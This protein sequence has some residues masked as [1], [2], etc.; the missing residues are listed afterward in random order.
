MDVTFPNG[1]EETY[2]P[3][4]FHFHAPSDHT[5]FD[6]HYDLEMHIVH[7]HKTSKALGAVLSIM[8]DHKIAANVENPFISS[9]SPDLAND[10]SSFIVV[11]ETYCTGYYETE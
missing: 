10:E 9:L 2:K 4:N 11:D 5:M 6:R 3:L 1:Q 8:F 7:V